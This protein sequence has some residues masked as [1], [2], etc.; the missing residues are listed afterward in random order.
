MVLAQEQATSVRRDA[1]P[2]AASD[3]P[4]PKPPNWPITGFLMRSPIVEGFQG[5]EMQA[6]QDSGEAASH[7]VEPLRIDR[8]APDI[9]LCLFNGR[10]GRIEIKQPPE[11]L[12]FG[13]TKLEDGFGKLHLRGEDGTQ[14]DHKV[15]ATMR[16]ASPDVLDIASFAES[17]RELLGRASELTSA[18]F[19]MQ[20][21]DLPDRAIFDPTNRKRQ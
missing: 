21:I 2:G 1:R 11:G 10:V 8:L 5:L 9:L 7:L 15:A 17:I 19:A 3:R 6:W 13:L 14:A 12:H 4:A 18:G 20:M 16:T